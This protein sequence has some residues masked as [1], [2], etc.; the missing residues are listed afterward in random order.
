MQGKRRLAGV[1]RPRQVKTSEG[2]GRR[3]LRP[4]PKATP[5][6]VAFGINACAAAL[7][8][9]AAKR[10]LIAEGVANP[11]LA[12]LAEQ[13]EAAGVPVERVPAARL[14]ELTGGGVHQGVLARIRNLPEIDLKAA[15]AEPGPAVV[16]LLDRI[17]DPQN[18][19]AILRTAVA[20]GAR[21]VV[22]P[23]RRG[24]TL[25]PGVH[26]ASAGMSFF[27]PVASPQN[28]AQAVRLL[29]ERGYWVVAADAGAGAADATRFDWPARSVLVL[30]NEGEGVS[31]L[32]LD[33]ADFRVAL[34][35]CPPAESLNVAVA[36]G[37][38]LYL[39]RRQWPAEGG[40]PTG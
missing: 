40:G 7:A 12:Q 15:A 31:R 33:L 6:D 36:C 14:D 8:A 9:R 1:E 28:L 19:G 16:L 10:L 2:T 4:K 35:M 3:R 34:P 26:R 18:V 37:A 39:W 13:A 22:L 38:L 32:L 24:A 30:G 20:V 25:T 5:D 11:R 21:A 23:K 17:T 27:A 29:Q